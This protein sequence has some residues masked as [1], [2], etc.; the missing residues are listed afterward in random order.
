MGEITL[1]EDSDSREF[2]ARWEGKNLEDSFVWN[3]APPW[4]PKK[5]LYST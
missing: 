1:A 5:T 3:S 2:Y 4:K